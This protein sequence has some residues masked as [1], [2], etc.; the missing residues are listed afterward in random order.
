MT[1]PSLLD[2]LMAPAEATPPAAAVFAKPI[3][4]NFYR[5]TDCLSVAAIDGKPLPMLRQDGEYCYSYGRCQQCG[6]RIEHM[7]EVYRDRLIRVDLQCPCDARCT[8]ALGPNCD[9]QCGGA[10]HG[11]QALVTVRT[12][13]GPIPILGIDNPKAAAQAI[14]YRKLIDRFRS[15]WDAR[16]GRVTRAKC[17]GEYLAG[18]DFELYLN[19]GYKLAGLRAANELR[20]HAGRTRKLEALI[21]EVTK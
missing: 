12:D 7:G 1:Q 20:S 3:P 2:I 9:C 14:A 11:S 8:G 18:A 16:Y 5:C 19:G 6:G 4:R 17:Q 13:Q 15:A 21:S 10:N